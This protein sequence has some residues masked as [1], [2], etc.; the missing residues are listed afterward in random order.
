MQGLV[1]IEKFIKKD[2]LKAILI[3]IERNFILTY[4]VA[5]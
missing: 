1:L 3:T 4:A 2:F 5:F